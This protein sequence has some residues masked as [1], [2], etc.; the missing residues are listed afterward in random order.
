MSPVRHSVAMPELRVRLGP[1]RVVDL[2]DDLRDAERLGRELGRHDVAV[3]ALGH[4]QED[5]GAL[6]AG[7]A[8]DVLVGAVAADRPAAERR[9]QAVERVGPGVDDDDLVTGPV[10]GVGDGRADAAA[11]HDDDLHDASSDIGSRTTQTVHG[12][13][14]RTYGMVRPMAK[15]PPN[16]VRNGTP[17]TIRSASRSTASSTIAAPTSRAWSRT[18]SRRLLRLLGDRLG[19]VEHALDLLGSA[20]DVGVERQRPVDLDDVDRDQL[21]LVRRG[22]ARRRG[23]RCGRRSVRR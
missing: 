3:V 2:G 18:G 6:G 9:R 11:A 17:R 1:H 5:V 23:G 22:P 19:E 13:F 15:S 20:G 7:A 10:V 12:A 14:C 4:G 16:R 21:G 8:Q